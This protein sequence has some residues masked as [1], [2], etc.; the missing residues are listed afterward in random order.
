MI[1]ILYFIF[2]IFSIYLIYSSTIRP[3]A[4]FLTISFLYA[5]ILSQIILIKQSEIKPIII[6]IEILILNLDLIWGVSLNY[7]F[8]ISR[9]DPIVHT[10]YLSNLI[11]NFHVT[12]VFYD[13]KTFPLW[14]IFCAIIY[15]IFEN[16][17][18]IQKTMFLANGFI[19]S[20]ILIII[21]LIAIRIFKDIKIALLSSLFISFYP[22]VI[23]Y[24]MSSIPRSVIFLLEVLVVLLLLD[25]K[26]I[27]KLSLAIFLTFP[28]ILYHLP[29]IL[30]IILLFILIFFL[31]KIYGLREEHFISFRYLIISIAITL[32]NFIYYSNQL[33]ESIINIIL[34]DTPS[35]IVSFSI[36]N[37]PIM[38]LFN[39][40]Q[41]SFILFFV[42][43]G[44][45]FALN[46][47]SIPSRGKIFCLV[48]LF[49][50]PVSFPGPALLITKLLSDFNIS[51]FEEYTFIFICIAGAVGLRKAFQ[52]FHNK[53]FFV[54]LA[55]FIIMVFLSLTND[56]IASDN[57]LIKRP[58]YTYY[59]TSQE[60]VAFKSIA[61]IAQG[62][63]LSDYVTT[64]YLM[65]SPFKEKSHILEADR[66]GTK[67]FKNNS[68][69]IF[70]IRNY[71]L[72]KRPLLIY[73]NEDS[74]FKFNPSWKSSL[75][76]YYKDLKLWDDLM[77]L[78]KIY[79]TECI[80]AFN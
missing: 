20:F 57:P 47:K 78:N 8:F 53:K 21:Y 71:E 7:D 14:H 10:W 73:P 45:Y 64:R 3:L 54:I 43:F 5:L 50:V 48:G 44:F 25:S 75:S 80:D 16:I 15:F 13:Y 19:F 18:S 34:I 69:D 4:Y 28:V 65:N 61:S 63:V 35:R 67:L 12:D 23:L 9:T 39:Y 41:Y 51:R 56:F 6:L 72:K 33:F 68:L 62:Y 70:L 76:Y 46:S 29:S 2:L 37:T 49:S 32:M 40:L 59:L 24:G 26:S 55:L 60:E 30:F 11:N 31:D 52:R 1:R 66:L 36:I 77:K 42:L 38:E 74:Y 17:I 27:T 58:F 79:S 22:P